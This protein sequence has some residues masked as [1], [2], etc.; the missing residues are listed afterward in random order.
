VGIAAGST[1]GIGLHCAGARRAGGGDARGAV[2]EGLGGVAWEDGEVCAG[3]VLG[4]GLD[5]FG[6][7]PFGPGKHGAGSGSVMAANPPG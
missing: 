2:W 4:A 5:V 3:G 1:W 6:V 7:G